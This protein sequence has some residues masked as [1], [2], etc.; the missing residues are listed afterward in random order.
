MQKTI[1]QNKNINNKVIFIIR[2]KEGINKKE[3]NIT[4]KVIYVIKKDNSS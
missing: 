3:I 4:N 1:K 2:L